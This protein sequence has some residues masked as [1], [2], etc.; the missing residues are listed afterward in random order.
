MTGGI[1]RPVM[2]KEVVEQLGLKPGDDVLDCTVGAGGHAEAILEATSPDGKLYGIDRDGEIL[3]LAERRLERF[4]ARVV[5]RQGRFD[6]ISVLFPEIGRFDGILFD[7]GV[8]SLQLD[9]SERGFSFSGKG[10]LDM[11]MDRTAGESAADLLAR[12]SEEELGSILK[13][14]GEER[15]ARRVA[16]SIVR[17]RER[18]PITETDELERLI[19]KAVPPNYRHGRIHPATRTFQALRIAVNHETELLEAALPGAVA[20]LKKGGRICVLA[21]HSLEDRIVKRSF[22]TMERTQ[23]EVRILSKKPLTPDLEETRANPRARSAKMRV[24]ERI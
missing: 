15:Y 12:L 21:F 4:G 9:R 23:G 8:S 2:L 17:A 24:A 10:P 7:L 13:S 14:Y 6:R 11:R 16:R 5:L 1:H 19:Y 18:A 20:H 22:R 3:P